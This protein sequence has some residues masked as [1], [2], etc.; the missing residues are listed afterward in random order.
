[1]RRQPAQVVRLTCRDHQFPPNATSELVS[2]SIGPDRIIVTE[3]TRKWS[4]IN[5]LTDSA[6]P[7]ALNDNDMRI[8]R[9]EFSDARGVLQSALDAT[10]MSP[11]HAVP[12]LAGLDTL[13]N[14]LGALLSGAPGGDSGLDLLRVT[15][16]P[17]GWWDDVHG[18]NPGGARAFQH[19]DPNIGNARRGQGG[20]SYS[21]HG[22]WQPSVSSVDLPDARDLAHDPRGGLYADGGRLY[23]FES[24]SRYGLFIIR[25]DS[26]VYVPFAMLKNGGAGGGGFGDGLFESKVAAGQN[27][28]LRTVQM[29]VSPNGR[30]AAIKIKRSPTY[31][32]EYARDS[33][34]VIVSLAGE[35]V[36]G[37][38]TYRIVQ[39]DAGAS[40]SGSRWMP[41]NSMAL[42]DSNLYFLLSTQRYLPYQSWA[43]HYL[44]RYDI[45]G[46]ATSASL[47]PS[48]GVNGNWPQQANT[49]MQ[50]T[51]Q[52]WDL[53]PYR[54]GSTSQ[55]ARPYH[56]YWAE[57][58]AN[59]ME[60][61]LAPT[62]FRVSR[63]GRAVAFLAG[64]NFFS[65]NHS[66][67]YSNY[68]WVDFQ[69]SGARQASFARRHSTMGS[70]RG[71]AISSGPEEYGMW[72]RYNGPTTGLEIADDGLR[73]AF[74]YNTTT[75]SVRANY[76]ASSSGNTF[77]RSRDDI[78]CCSTTEK[79][80]WAS[81]GATTEKAVT[82]SVFTGAHRWRFGAL[83]FTKAADGLVFWAGAPALNATATSSTYQMSYN[84]TGSFYAS[85]N[86]ESTDAR[87]T[88][89]LP[90]SAGGSPD[91]DGQL[92]TAA[93]PF[94]PFLTTGL[95]NR[96][97]AILPN[98]GFLS[99]N[100]SFMY[101]SSY[102]ALSSKDGTS[103]RLVAL[104]VDSL[105][106]GALNGHANGLGFAVQNWP[107]R[108]GFIAAYSYPGYAYRPGYLN[109]PN[110]TQGAGRQ[111]MAKDTGWVFWGSGYQYG[112]AAKSSSTTYGGPVHPTHQYGVYGYGGVG[113]YG[114]NA[115]VGGA[116]AQLDP[117]GSSSAGTKERERLHYIEV[118]D[119]GSSLVYVSSGEAR[120]SR[121]DREQV[122]SVRDIKFDA[123]TGAMHA[124]FNRGSDARFLESADGRA[125]EAMA[126]TNQG[127]DIYYAFK[128]GAKDETQREMV[129]ARF[130][131]KGAL[132]TKRFP[133][134]T[135]RLNV[136][137]AGR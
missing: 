100:R 82:A 16:N 56:R 29:T 77:M 20:P 109:A 14:P 85:G 93:S 36:F 99:K 112:S 122:V 136:L 127:R 57:G 76:S 80:A 71:Y 81:Q 102:G 135:G 30:Y 13:P 17:T 130:D 92:Y 21:T 5:N 124:A 54:E 1:M 132:T 2:V 110:T 120:Y 96:Y 62:P 106:P 37:G 3:S 87:V 65:T 129:R 31:Q 95:N 11:S 8:R 115:E 107:F 86:L 44:M 12:S 103:G 23:A 33:R 4:G 52:H 67:V 97:G 117:N 66:L 126:I 51:F 50:T 128:A 104:N 27:S 9:V 118:A 108:R 28:L 75:S 60:N 72:G 119:D 39:P 26:S 41:A 90:T 32:L 34:I 78:I 64:S 24:D 47:L 123:L 69:G 46:P 137:Y 98:G 63:D 42:T 45:H 59:F 10:D 101:I 40:G 79:D 125:G 91:G 48:S 116:V 15:V 121:Y 38:Q 73:M 22:N 53:E 131:D 70:G 18:I 35:K 88:S 68:A 105:K 58:G 61:A 134:T 43:G 111:V 74:V 25:S 83:A 84:L 49:P 114:F 133:T 19:S 89:M 6:L 94:N 113:L 55:G 7:F